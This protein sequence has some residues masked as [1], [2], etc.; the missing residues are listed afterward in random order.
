[1]FVEIDFYM[2]SLKPLPTRDEIAKKL[3]ELINGTIDRRQA[4]D[5]A[6]QW[7][8]IFDKY[9]RTDKKVTSAI[10]CLAA[11]DLITTD[12]P[13]LYG[14]SDFESWLEELSN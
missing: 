11:A 14:Q 6:A 13:Y 9:E 3:R 8:T 2:T 12:R 7:I 4:A 5:W 1:V 10:S